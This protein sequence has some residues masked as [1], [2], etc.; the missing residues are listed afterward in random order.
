MRIDFSCLL[1]MFG[2]ADFSAV[3]S[4]S[5]NNVEDRDD[6]LCVYRIVCFFSESILSQYFAQVLLLTS[7]HMDNKILL[8]SLLLA[9]TVW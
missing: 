4:Q 8:F 2:A 5:L 3:T 6:D 7:G 9:R 1:P